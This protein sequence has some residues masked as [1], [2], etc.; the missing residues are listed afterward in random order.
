MQTLSFFA[1]VILFGG[2]MMLLG[3]P[4]WVRPL[5][6]LCLLALGGLLVAAPFQTMGNLG[7]S[8]R[9]PLQRAAEACPYDAARLRAAH[10]RWVR[11]WPPDVTVVGCATDRVIARS[12]GL[13]RVYD[14]RRAAHDLCAGGKIV[15]SDLIVRGGRARAWAVVDCAT[16]KAPDSPPRG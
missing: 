5:R 15:A 8:S 3:P 11:S 7:G 1:F 16:A 6:A 10:A 2:A 14:V 9:V 4:Q 12:G 13:V